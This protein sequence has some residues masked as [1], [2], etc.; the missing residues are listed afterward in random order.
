MYGISDLKTAITNPH[1]I[2]TELNRLYHG[3]FHRHE[4]NPAG[5]DIFDEDWDILVVL[6][7]CRYDT[8][9]EVIDNQG[10]IGQLEARIS[11]GSA[12]REWIRAN[13]DGKQLHDLVYIDSNGYFAQLKDDID[14]EVHKYHLIDNDAF[15]GI[16]VHPDKVTK[17][18][19]RFADEYSD[20]RLLIHYMQPHQPYFGPTGDSIEHAAGFQATVRENNLDNATIRQA[21]TENLEIVLNSVQELLTDLDGRVV[22]TSDHGELLGDPQSPLPIQSYYGH[23]AGLYVS[24]LVTVPWFVVDS[25]PRRHIREEDPQQDDI[26]LNEDELDE[27]LRGLGYKV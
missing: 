13:F 27:K 21:Y 4:Y 24:E 17:V 7:A 25:G 15:G 1:Y 9:A 12:T 5:I 23:P 26:S 19:R 10:F 11:R 2:G 18:A 14:T 22:I 16:S 6:D 3:R 8:F 20:K